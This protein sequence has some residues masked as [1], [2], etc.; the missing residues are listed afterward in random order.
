M[1]RPQDFIDR[2]RGLERLE[3]FLECH[4]LGVYAAKL[5]EAVACEDFKGNKRAEMAPIVTAAERAHARL[6]RRNT[7]S[8]ALATVVTALASVMVTIFTKTV[9]DGLSLT[10][11]LI[12][13]GTVLVG[14]SAFLVITRVNEVPLTRAAKAC[15]ELQKVAL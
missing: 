3:N 1:I 9:T 14:A 2:A 11:L 10:V 8:Q 7:A 4:L 6:A 5:R 15:D 13:A 12:I